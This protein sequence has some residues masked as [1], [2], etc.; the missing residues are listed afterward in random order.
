MNKP[1]RLFLDY[2]KVERNYSD[3]TIEAYSEDIAIYFDFLLKEGVLFD[4]ADLIVIRNFLSEQLESG[5]SKKTCKRRLSALRHFYTYL[6][7]NKMVKDN[8]FLYLDS[9]KVETKYPKALY[10][11]ELEKLFL[12][13]DQ[14]EDELAPRDQAILK[15]LYYSGLRASELIGIEMHMINLNSRIVRVIGKGNKER[16]V[17]FSEDCKKSLEKYITNLRPKL[18]V[19]SKIPT[20]SLFLNNNGNKLTL[21][22]LE[23]ILD[24]IEKKVG[25]YVGLHPHLLRHTFAS[26]LLENGADLRVIQELLGHESLNSTQIYT[27]VNEKM[28]SETYQSAHPRAKK[29]D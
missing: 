10:K 14:R 19:K 8:P 12:L 21:R 22:G 5:N 11:D 3:R 25:D 4:D 16:I 29:K 6:L 18:L 24:Q 2:L 28:M 20:A 1:T 26:H 23:Y 13:N 7:K 9:P 15:I 17:P 27:H